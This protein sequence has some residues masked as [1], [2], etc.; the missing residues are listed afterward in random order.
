VLEAFALEG[1]SNFMSV[2]SVQIHRLVL[3]LLYVLYDWTRN[4]PIGHFCGHSCSTSWKIAGT[5]QTSEISVEDSQNSTF[6]KFLWQ[7]GKETS[8]KS[9]ITKITSARFSNGDKN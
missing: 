5:M 9:I 1:L 4:Y 2:N 8:E 7:V 3:K 6:R